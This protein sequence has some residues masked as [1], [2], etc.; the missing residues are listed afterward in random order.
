MLFTKFLSVRRIMRHLVVIKVTICIHCLSEG[1]RKPLRYSRYSC[2]SLINTPANV[3]LIFIIECRKYWPI[4]SG[5]L[6]LYT[7]IGGAGAPNSSKDDSK[8]ALLRNK[9]N[10][11]PTHYLFI[12]AKLNTWYIYIY[13]LEHIKHTYICCLCARLWMHSL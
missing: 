5:H 10:N 4:N 11:M 7:L 8:F 13:I 3:H 2:Q 9:L 1:L 6:L 12:C